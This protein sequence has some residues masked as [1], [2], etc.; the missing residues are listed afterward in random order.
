[1]RGTSGRS[2]AGNV[3]VELAG[4]S[5]YGTSS[6]LTKFTNSSQQLFNLE[7]HLKHLFSSSDLIKLTTKKTSNHI[8]VQRKSMIMNKSFLYQLQLG[9]KSVGLG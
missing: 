8:A 5:L 4:E 9:H 6:V 2:Q 3:A 7:T 1:M